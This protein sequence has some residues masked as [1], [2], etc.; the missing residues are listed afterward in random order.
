MSF[1]DQDDGISGA[2]RTVYAMVPLPGLPYS[3]I[4][5]IDN[6]DDDQNEEDTS[7]DD[8]EEA[9]SSEGSD[10]DANDDIAAGEPM[11][12]DWVAVKIHASEA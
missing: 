2:D 3:N 9:T 8:D 12:G 5:V 1:T 11:T 10:D 6:D 4:S 7:D